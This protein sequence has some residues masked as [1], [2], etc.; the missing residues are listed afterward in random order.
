MTVSLQKDKVLKPCWGGDTYHPEVEYYMLD[1]FDKEE[2]R[3]VRMPFMTSPEVALFFI[4]ND[5]HTRAKRLRV[6]GENYL[7]QPRECWNEELQV[8]VPEVITNRQFIFGETYE[9]CA[10]RTTGI[11]SQSQLT[12]ESF[13]DWINRI[14]S[15]WNKK[16]TL[17]PIDYKNGK[18]VKAEKEE[19][20]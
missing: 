19:K 18:F 20:K 17:N 9:S 12:N 2:I 14:K 11:P 6:Q 16:F 3:W 15:N 1:Y 7:S 4:T 13:E 5:L 8:Y 10:V